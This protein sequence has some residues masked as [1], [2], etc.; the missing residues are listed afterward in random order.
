MPA[1]IIAAVAVGAGAVAATTV[2]YIGLGIT[3]AGMVTKNS[4]LTKIGAQIGLGAGVGAIATSFMGS[5]ASAAAS[6]A[7]SAASGAAEAAASG[8]S[9]TAGMSALPTQ[10]TM[11]A[12]QSFVSNTASNLGSVAKL[13]ASAFDTVDSS[14]KQPE[15]STPP[16]GS[17]NAFNPADNIAQPEVGASQ[18]ANLGNNGVVTPA[19][20]AGKYGSFFDS[21]KD[22]D[23]RWNKQVLTEVGKIGVGALQGYAKADETN[24][25]LEER[26]RLTDIQLANANSPAKLS[27][28][29]SLMKRA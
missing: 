27:Y 7:G 3:V 6:G 20:T 11:Q 8:G 15:Q 18:G 16:E 2:A 10:L 17:V 4:T 25:I 22:P 1:A 26:R 12:P 19:D 21:F 9:Y 28:Q 5:A 24:A 23:G 29:S 13:G 14:I